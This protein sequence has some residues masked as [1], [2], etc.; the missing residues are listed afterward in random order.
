MLNYINEKTDKYI[1]RTS[2]F[3]RLLDQDSAVPMH[4][5][6]KNSK[7][8]KVGCNSKRRKVRWDSRR[9]K[10]RCNTLGVNKPAITVKWQLLW[11]GGH[12]LKPLHY[13][14]QTLINPTATRKKLKPDAISTLK[15]EEEE[16][17]VV[18][19]IV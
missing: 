10:V 4:T 19:L 16:N 14:E 7:C 9:R 17:V 13:K 5:L 11:C 18:C 15:R 1:W 2:Y 3:C 6:P 8:R 12:H